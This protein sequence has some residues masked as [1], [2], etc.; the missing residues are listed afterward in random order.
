M[1]NN[2]FIELDLPEAADLADL[3]GVRYD[4]DSARNLARRLK[5]LLGSRQYDS[6]LV[7]ALTTAILVRYSRSFVT[8]V[9]KRLKD[10]ALGML[11]DEQRKKHDQLRAWRDK[12]IAHSVNAFEENRPVARYWVE[13]VRD[14]GFVSVECNQTKVIGLGEADLD[15]V[16]ELT[17]TLLTY[18][19]AHLAT[20]KTR[21]L[22]IV[23]SM[24]IE[25]LFDAA[26]DRRDV[27]GNDII[28]QR[29]PRR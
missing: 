8:G 11:T 14:E 7:D 18:V 13:R 24:A 9:R 15:D 5:K 12:H 25:A 6:E 10:D 4:L 19:D 27:I 1:A 2:D 20:E 16:I 17:T 23:R 28:D 29:R 3:T 21:V 22:G 26:P